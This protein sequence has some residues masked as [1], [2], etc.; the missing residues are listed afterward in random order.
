M[1]RKILVAE[2]LDAG[3]LVH[4]SKQWGEDSIEIHYHPDIKSEDLGK[5]LASGKFD[6]LVVGSKDVLPDAIEM[7]AEVKPKER[8]CIVRAGSNTSTIAKEAAAKHGIAVMNTPGANSQ[9]TAEEI[10]RKI[11]YLIGEG[12]DIQAIEDV[13][14]GVWK[15]RNS[16][17]HHSMD[18]KKIALIGAGAIGQKVAIIAK[19]FG[20]NVV[21]FS[22]NLTAEKAEMM[23]GR[24]AETLEDALENADIVSIQVPY[25]MPDSK[26]GQPTYKMIG[27]EQI[28]LLNDGAIIVN[29]SRRDVIDMD[30]ATQALGTGKLSGFG[31]DTMLK[32][33]KELK[34]THPKIFDCRNTHITPSISTACFETDRNVSFEALKRIEI[35]W[36]E[37]RAVSVVNPDFVKVFPSQQPVLEKRENAQFPE[38]ATILSTENSLLQVN[39][40]STSSIRRLDFMKH[41][42]SQIPK[43]LKS[44]FDES[45]IKVEK[46]V[47][48]GVATVHVSHEQEVT[49]IEYGYSGV[50]VLSPMS[51][52]AAIENAKRLSLTSSSWKNWMINHAVKDGVLSELAKEHKTTKLFE[53]LEKQGRRIYGGRAIIIPEAN[54]YKGESIETILKDAEHRYFDE[55]SSPVYKAIGDYLNSLGGKLQITPDFGPNAST[56]D[57]LHAHTPHALGIAEKNNGSGGKSPYSVTSILATLKQLKLEQQPK[58]TPITVIGAAGALGS[59]ICAYL[60]KNG[61]TNVTVCDLQYK[62][63]PPKNLPQGWKIEPAVPGKFTDACLDRSGKNS[64]I[65]TAAYGDE[66]LNSNWQRMKPG[67]HWIAAQNKD[68]PEKGEGIAFARHLKQKGILHI[69]G[70]LL[71][72]GGTT[73]SWVEWCARQNQLP[74]SKELA[75]DLV[76]K[77][78]GKILDHMIKETLKDGT[79]PYEAMLAYADKQHWQEKG[80]HT[81]KL[82]VPNLVR[83]RL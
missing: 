4:F 80:D 34:Q 82:L 2:A 60:E 47:I 61:F 63:T 35:F 6:A 21:A 29:I 48:P 32:E 66:M 23:G 72:I 53:V 49:P 14:R 50:R 46:I 11:I 17:Y 62:N 27:K 76:E 83:S 31:L 36:K 40:T 67:T 74:F 12:K 43:K 39:N 18:G 24:Q 77:V 16:Y 57:K 56:A 68:V 9:S 37:N 52:E 19:A 59:G 69:P 71:T 15:D 45:N 25:V 65:I 20:M 7:W 30:A 42:G 26:V 55:V 28:E 73:A 3:I 75:H 38:L 41:Q 1:K 70:Q 10:I 58:D 33:V 44:L 54:N 8:L 13:K 81:D 5:T 78:T 51:D 22:P 79:T 64:W